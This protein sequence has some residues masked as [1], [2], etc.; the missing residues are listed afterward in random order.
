MNAMALMQ[1]PGAGMADNC[2]HASL[3]IWSSCLSVFGCVTT[4]SLGH[5]EAVY[6]SELAILLELHCQVTQNMVQR[7][8]IS[9]SAAAVYKLLTSNGE[10]FMALV[11]MCGHRHTIPDAALGPEVLQIS[12]DMRQAKKYSEPAAVKPAVLQ[13]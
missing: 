11:H 2:L 6:V 9:C 5:K 7:H 3:L 1:N 12:S 13:A 4:P 10:C 8:G